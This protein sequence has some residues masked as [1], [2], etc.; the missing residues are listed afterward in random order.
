MEFITEH[1][2][3]II[4]V[5]LYFGA[6]AVAFFFQDSQHPIV[7]AVV[8]FSRRV[9]LDITGIDWLKRLLRP[10]PTV[11]ATR[12]PVFPSQ[13][14]DGDLHAA[15]H[16]GGQWHW[17]HSSLKGWFPLSESEAAERMLA[18]GVTEDDIEDLDE[19]GQPA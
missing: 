16:K 7:Q 5:V 8:N 11:R 10:A 12:G 19:E 3:A 15:Y 6:A 14:S 1:L 13:P 18:A 9:S 17:Y 2:F 4:G